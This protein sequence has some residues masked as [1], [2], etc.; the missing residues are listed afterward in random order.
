M[1]YKN[2]VC[3]ILRDG[4]SKGDLVSF[5]ASTS[6]ADRYGDVINQGGWD[7]DKYRANPVILLN[8]NA[9]ALPI[10]KGS[11]D[12]VDG[13]LMVDVEFDM[14]DPQAKEVA[15][16]TKAGFLNAVS[17]G[18]NPID[19]TPRAMLEKSHPAHGQSG[20]YFDK[21]E[22]LE[23]SI[24]TIPANGEAVAA[25][26]YDMTNRSFKIS[27]LKHILDVDVRDDVVIVTYA[28]EGMPADDEPIEEAYN[29]EDLEDLED[30]EKGAHMDEDEEDPEKDK[31]KEKDFLTPQERAFLAAL[32]S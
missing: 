25:K 24:V 16:K 27:N 15:R 11:V 30:E 3:E 19:S 1:Q 18:F 7:L 29:D 23:I 13:Q 14:D 31:D 28:R 8:H 6:S 32:L 12:V 2:L 21:A 9:N 4:A 17:V 20:Q 22:L 10:G 5:V 26:G